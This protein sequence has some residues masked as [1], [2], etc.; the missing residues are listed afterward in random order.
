MPSARR[1]ANQGCAFG[2]G[3]TFSAA[4]LVVDVD[5]GE[6]G[7][8]LVVFVAPVVTGDAALD[9]GLVDALGVAGEMVVPTA[10]RVDAGVLADVG[11]PPQAKSENTGSTDTNRAIR[12]P[13]ERGEVVMLI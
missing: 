5:D 4:A 8:M 10:P 3:E 11:D 9:D 1:A 12:R 13:V 7:P 2:V 6:V